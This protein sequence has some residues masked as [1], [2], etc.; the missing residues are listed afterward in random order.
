[1]KKRK[2]CILMALEAVVLSFC[3]CSYVEEDISKYIADIIEKSS[4]PAFEH[5]EDISKY[6]TSIIEDTTLPAFEYAESNTPKHANSNNKLF[7]RALKRTIPDGYFESEWEDEVETPIEVLQEY[8]MVVNSNTNMIGLCDYNGNIVIDA[9]YSELSFCALINDVPYF[10]A[11]YEGKWGVINGEGNVTIPFDDDYYNNSPEI[12][13]NNVL[14]FIIEDSDIVTCVI[15]DITQGEIDRFEVF[16]SAS[17]IAPFAHITT[18]TILGPNNW[19]FLVDYP[20][21]LGIVD[22]SGKTLTDAEIDFYGQPDPRWQSATSD[23]YSRQP[24]TSNSTGRDYYILDSNANIISGPYDTVIRYDDMFLCTDSEE[25]ETLFDPAKNQSYN[26]DVLDRG[27]IA[28]IFEKN[29]VLYNN[30]EGIFTLELSSGNVSQ[31]RQDIPENPEEHGELNKFGSRRYL[32][33]YGKTFV[34]ISNDT[35]KIS[36][37][38]GNTVGDERYYDFQDIGYGALL[39][40]ENGDWVYLNEDGHLS[41]SNGVFHGEGDMASTYNN[42]AII[43]YWKY[44]DIPCVVVEEGAN[45]VGYAL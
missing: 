13:G 37:L 2:I 7:S 34:Y 33:I 44:K 11:T 26:A 17:G 31:I 10:F 35:Y 29:I 4:L 3:A 5:T 15:F 30:K 9:D 6:I 45:Q 38:E 32:S 25:S 24:I 43:G 19:V 23:G 41:E 1:M 36:D 42:C 16:A 21:S 28:G 20:Y 8:T 22:Y 27:K 18:Y 14:Q 40:K 39:K 12:L